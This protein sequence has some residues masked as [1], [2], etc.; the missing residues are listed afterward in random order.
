MNSLFLLFLKLNLFD[1][2][3]FQISGY[4]FY[5]YICDRSIVVEYCIISVYFFCVNNNYNI[6]E[7]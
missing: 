1:I 2:D 7:L 4:K 6:M 5:E 3:N